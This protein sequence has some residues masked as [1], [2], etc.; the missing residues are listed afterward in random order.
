MLKT[1]SDQLGGPG[2]K[3]SKQG[4]DQLIKKLDQMNDSATITWDMLGDKLGTFVAIYILNDH[5]LHIFIVN[6]DIY[7]IC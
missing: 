5:I 6:G 2:G 3:I 1:Y 4:M 7:T